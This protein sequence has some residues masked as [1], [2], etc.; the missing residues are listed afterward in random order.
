MLY[1]L[2]EL[3][4]LEPYRKAPAV[5][6][7]S[8]PEAVKRATRVNPR[9]AEKTLARYSSNKDHGPPLQS[10]LVE[11]AMTTPVVTLLESDGLDLAKQIMIEKQI[12]HI[13]IVS[14]SKTLVGII[15][16]RDLLAS[17]GGSLTETMSKR[18]VV[19][20]PNTTL[21]EAARW[22][23]SEGISCLPVI[24]NNHEVIGIFTTSDL[25]KAL[26]LKG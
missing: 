25:L 13:P 11:S 3:R 18:V 1:V 7:I 20:E 15:S 16:D 9:K 14:T 24:Q 8:P 6:S 22:M 21:L 5:V 4:T 23:L 26:V 12:R 17:K 2:T 10:L 19:A